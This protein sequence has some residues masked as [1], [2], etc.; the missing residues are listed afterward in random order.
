MT[1][2]STE[3]VVRRCPGP[4]ADDASAACS[5]PRCERDAA[6]RV[7]DRDRGRWR[8]ICLPHAERLHPSLEIQVW[9]E[10]GYM[11]P[12]ELGIPDGPP[13]EPDRVRGAA[14]RDEVERLMGWSE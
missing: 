9:L 4:S 12:I 2:D 14:F 10:S 11:R 6:F 3:P 8:P 7:Y 5:N 13:G 1:R